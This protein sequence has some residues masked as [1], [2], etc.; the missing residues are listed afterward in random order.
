MQT[1]LDELKLCGYGRFTLFQLVCDVDAYWQFSCFPYSQFIAPW[2]NRCFIS[3]GLFL[4]FP[5]H[6]FKPHSITFNALT[7]AETVKI[8]EIMR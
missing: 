3:K 7:K 5:S 6:C 8:C 4:L 1:F 2:K